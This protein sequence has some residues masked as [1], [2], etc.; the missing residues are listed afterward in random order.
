MHKPSLIA[1]VTASSLFATVAEAGGRY[2]G[3]YDR[4]YRETDYAQ[5]ISSRPIYSQVR[6]SEPRRECWDERVTYRDSYR[7]GGRGSAFDNTAGAV[8]G[9][10]IGGAA[11]H[12]LSEGSGKQIA[13]AIG[14]LI[15]ASVGSNAVRNSYSRGDDDYRERVAYEP[16][17]RT[18]E[19]SRYEER[20][21]GYDVTYRYNGRTYST[22]MP[23]DPGNRIAVEVEVAPA[24]Y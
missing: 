10:V 1:L 6:V 4:D 7:G 18:V 5:V 11:G 3:G 16:R 23:Y 19:D 12:Q 22:R 2:H 14:A 8:L 9:G 20:I 21:E 15:G 24:R 17:C 13:T